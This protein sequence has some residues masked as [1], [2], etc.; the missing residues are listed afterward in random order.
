MPK[1]KQ[2][3]NTIETLKLVI[4]NMKTNNY[5]FPFL[6]HSIV[7]L[8]IIAIIAIIEIYRE[9]TIKPQYKPFLYTLVIIA[10]IT[11][12]YLTYLTYTFNG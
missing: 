8:G 1:R 2:N 10:L 9:I 11:S 3:N 7:L 6:I 12:I 5:L 4:N